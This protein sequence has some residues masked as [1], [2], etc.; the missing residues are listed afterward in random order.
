MPIRDCYMQTFEEIA[1]KFGEEVSGCEIGSSDSLRKVIGYTRRYVV[2][3]ES[4]HFRYNYYRRELGG[5]VARHD[6]CPNG[7][8]VIHLD[9]GCGPGLFS[10]VVR[11]YMH[12]RFGQDIGPVEHVGYDHSHNMI[13][14]ASLF[15]A[16]LPVTYDGRGYHNVDEI[17]DVLARTDCATSDAVVTLGHVL[18]Q[19]CDDA[20]A[21]RRFADIIQVL[22]PV[23]SCIV[24]AVDAYISENRRQAFRRACEQLAGVLDRMGIQFE[25][26]WMGATKSRMSARVC[27]GEWH[28]DR[29]SAGH[30]Q[31]RGSIGVANVVGTSE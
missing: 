5:A 25:D 19:I 6:Y 2:E 3:N 13:L 18:I 16:L 11:D 29:K 28:G 15:Q 9:L 4:V 7:R 12:E 21:M 23:N 20:D 31:R 26:Q 30:V 27:M 1:G 22:F 8:R 24:V 10:W 17:R 14:L